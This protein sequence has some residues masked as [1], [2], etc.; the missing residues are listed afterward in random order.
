MSKSGCLSFGNR[1]F[2]SRF[3][4]RAGSGSGEACE[5]PK[6]HSRLLSESLQLR[7]G[8]SSGIDHDLVELI[9]R[10]T[11]IRYA[12]ALAALPRPSISVMRLPRVDSRKGFCNNTCFGSRTCSFESRLSEYPDMN[13]TLVSG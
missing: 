10:D 4:S 12:L 9:K 6:R 7:A 1:T 8:K 2:G 13:S 5:T 3:F 11:R